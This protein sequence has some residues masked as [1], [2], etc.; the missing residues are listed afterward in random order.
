M[1]TSSSRSD[2]RSCI[3]SYRRNLSQ[4]LA[5]KGPQH[6]NTA[7]GQQRKSWAVG[8]RTDAKTSSSLRTLLNRLCGRSPAE[9][10]W[11]LHSPSTAI[12]AGVAPG[13]Q[14][15]PNMELRCVIRW[16]PQAGDWIVLA[17]G[18]N[19]GHSLLTADAEPIK[20]PLCSVTTRQKKKSDHDPWMQ[21]IFFS[22]FFSFPVVKCP[23]RNLPCIYSACCLHSD[24]RISSPPVPAPGIQ[25]NV[26]CNAGVGKLQAAGVHV[27]SERAS[28]GASNWRIE[29]VRMWGYGC[30]ST[31]FLCV[32]T[33]TSDPCHDRKGGQPRRRQPQASAV[34]KRP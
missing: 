26:R 1:I 25:Q 7:Q 30:V 2:G 20:I 6:R 31:H 15:L 3:G 4:G 32:P 13:G 12:P 5:N 9:S 33:L 18:L 27:D 29:S 34:W 10:A 28:P 14:Q 8:Q 24:S 22:F 17:C 16:S 23:P 21:S 19:A 11:F